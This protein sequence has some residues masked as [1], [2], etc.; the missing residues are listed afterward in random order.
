MA[1]ARRRWS[2]P[3]IFLK[4]ML[5]GIVLLTVGSLPFL[6]IGSIVVPIIL[7]PLWVACLLL[8]AYR[9]GRWSPSRG[10]IRSPTNAP[11]ASGQ[12]QEQRE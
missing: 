6:G 2:G 8:L 12:G 10:L 9:T 4:G 1:T 3:R 7:V 11:I 5:L